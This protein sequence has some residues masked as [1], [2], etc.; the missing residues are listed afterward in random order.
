MT[1]LVAPSMLDMLRICSRPREDEVEQ[2]Q[3][4][5]GNEWKTDDVAN[6]LYSRRGVKWCIKDEELAPVAVFGA[7]LVIPGV[8]QTW[9]ISS[10]E[11]WE[12]HWRAITRHSRRVMGAMFSDASA[13]RIQTMALASRVEACNWYEKGL[14]MTLE[15]IAKGF[16]VTGQDFAC[17]VRFREV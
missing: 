11:S 8:W 12:K 17:Y 2:Y 3:E 10:T 1:M 13:R 5:T 4:M 14:R 9:M 16:G 6:D 7:E 15:S